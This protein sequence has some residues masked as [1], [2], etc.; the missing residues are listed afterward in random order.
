MVAF[1]LCDIGTL[2]WLHFTDSASNP[3]LTC[4]PL[5]LTTVTS[6]ALP[7]AICPT[8][9]DYAMCGFIAATNI[10]NFSTHSM[11]SCTS[12]GLTSTN[13]CLS[14]IWSGVTCSGMAITT[15]DVEGIGLT[16]MV[17]YLSMMY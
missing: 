17:A 12:D 3:L 11:W 8:P 10:A 7:S 6:R 1:S 15:L 4:A 14:T 5:C 2:T 9:Q 16:G 13:P